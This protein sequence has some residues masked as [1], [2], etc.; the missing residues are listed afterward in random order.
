MEVCKVNPPGEYFVL[1]KSQKCQIPMFNYRSEMQE[2]EVYTSHHTTH[3]LPQY[4]PK[5]SQ[6]A[7]VIRKMSITLGGEE[8]ERIKT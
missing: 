3:T 6:T 8:P 7:S 2:R 5:T 1:I 4:Y